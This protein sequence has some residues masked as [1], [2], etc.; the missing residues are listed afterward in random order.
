MEVLV[1]GFTSSPVLPCTTTSTPPCGTG[2]QAAHAATTG[3]SGFEGFIAR[4]N[5]NL[6]SLLQTTF[7]GGGDDDLIRAMT[8]HPVSGEVLVAGDTF[9]TNLP[10]T[11]PATGCANGAQPSN[12]GLGDTFVARLTADLTLNDSTPDAF[13][14]APQINV[15]ASSVRTSSPVLIAG[16]T[17]AADIYL[18]GQPGSAYC[19]SST[20]SCSCDVSLTDVATRTPLRR[21]A[22]CACVTQRPPRRTG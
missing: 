10:C 15:P 13:A 3:G 12:A 14:F 6:T 20:P 4:I 21:T 22:T 5:A 9:S 8:I 16:I 18:D 19:V 1:A 11:S 17:G 2:A 7:L